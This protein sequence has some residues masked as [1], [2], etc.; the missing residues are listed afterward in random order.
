ML[1]RLLLLC[2]EGTHLL[3]A[4]TID[5][6]IA[7]AGAGSGAEVDGLGFVVEEKLDVIHKPEHRAGEFIVEVSLVFLDQLSARQGTDDFFQR[8]LRLGPR[9]AIANWRDSMALVLRLG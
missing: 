3:H 5:A 8:L 7:V 1:K 2:Y 4:F 6:Q 9:L